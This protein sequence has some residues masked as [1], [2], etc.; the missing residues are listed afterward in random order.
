M[1]HTS[2]KLTPSKNSQN[3]LG[4]SPTHE[5]NI[6]KTKKHDIGQIVSKFIAYTVTGLWIKISIKN[7][8]I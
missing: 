1:I 5:Y 8:K 4:T 6:I 2:E 7:K 3:V